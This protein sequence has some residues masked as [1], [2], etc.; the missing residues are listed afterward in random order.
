[1]T[2]ISV[3]TEKYNMGRELNLQ[4]RIFSSGSTLRGVT[5]TQQHKENDDWN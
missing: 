1:M 3:K 5:R 2:Y 4:E